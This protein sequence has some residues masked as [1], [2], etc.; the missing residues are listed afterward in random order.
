MKER[1]II[2][3]QY[4][5]AHERKKDNV[6]AVYV[7]A[8]VQHLCTALVSTIALHLMQHLCAAL[9]SRAAGF[10]Y[11]ITGPFDSSMNTSTR[12]HS[13]IRTIYSD[14]VEHA[15]LFKSI[16]RQH[17]CRQLLCTWCSI[18]AGFVYRVTGPFDSSMNTSTRAHSDIRIIYSDTVEHARLFKSMSSVQRYS[19]QRSMRANM[20][21]A[22]CAASGIMVQ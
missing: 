2:C 12:A 18:W 14:T 15:R 6:H 10:V 3:R 9:A 7:R 1:K 17:L 21:S 19:L 8:W 20:R 13:D 16:S 5:F 22:P 11:R 4:M